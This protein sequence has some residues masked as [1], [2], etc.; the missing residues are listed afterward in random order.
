[1]EFCKEAKHLSRWSAARK[2]YA[3][4]HGKKG[5]E[6]EANVQ[7]AINAPIDQ[8]LLWMPHRGILQIDDEAWL[9]WDSTLWRGALLEILWLRLQVR[10][11]TS[12]NGLE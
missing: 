10:P 6:T 11:L 2:E 8:E 5:R 4:H 3:A 7:A 9:Q 1:L 12:R